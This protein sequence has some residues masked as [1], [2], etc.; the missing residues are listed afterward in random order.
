MGP[1]TRWVNRPSQLRM[2]AAHRMWIQPAYYQYIPDCVN[3]MSGSWHGD[4]RLRVVSSVQL[5]QGSCGHCPTVCAVHLSAQLCT[6][7]SDGFASERGQNWHCSC[8]PCW[9]NTWSPRGRRC[10]FFYNNLPTWQR[11][12]VRWHGSESGHAGQGL[13]FGSRPSC[14]DSH[15]FTEIDDFKARS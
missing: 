3:L 7:R 9:H 10:L 2:V 11:G 8:C 12:R 1:W 13:W 14:C 15:T 5:A 6:M 4:T